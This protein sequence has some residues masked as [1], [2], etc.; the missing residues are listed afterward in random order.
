MATARDFVTLAM[1]EAG[2]VGIGQTPNSEDINNC[3]TLL[4][5]MLAQWQKRRWIVPNLI[6]ISAP[7]NNQRSNLIGPGQHY[8]TLRPDKIQ[9]AYFKQLSGGSSG[10][11]SGFDAGFG[12]IASSPGDVSYSLHPIYSYEDYAR[13]GLK[14]LNSWPNYF[15]Y[16]AAFP[17]GNV[18]IWPIPSN[19]YEIHLI[20]KGPIDFL[21]QL[22][23]GE[24]V[25]SGDTYIDGTYLAVPFVN[26]SSFGSGGTADIIVLGN[27]ITNV[28]IANGGN[29]YKI[30]D[31]LTLDTT[32]MGAA[33]A[34]FIWRVNNVT[35]SLDA[36]FNMPAEYEEAIHYN[37]C[38]RIVAFYQYPANPI[39]GKLAVLALN[40]IKNSNTQ[41][42][43]L[44]M[45]SSLRF[46]N[47]GGNGFYIFNADQF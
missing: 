12:G 41:I 2:V 28:V 33:G 4:H 42:S 9:A 38:V 19:Q 16:D 29:G 32:V 24:V 21:I 25:D 8:N 27:V 10:F 7:G 13:L 43:R 37:L 20:L 47:A 46:N 30:G 34:G 26:I 44:Q 35:D 22:L 1:K 40:T 45:P 6:D 17:Y 31:T 5:R 14:D 11:S 23:S 15:F 39:Q 18:F 36:E 3:F